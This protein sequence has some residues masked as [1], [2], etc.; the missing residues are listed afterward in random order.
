VI[1]TDP[2]YAERARQIGAELASLGGAQ[3]SVDLLETWSRRPSLYGVKR[4]AATAV[5]AALA[6]SVTQS[7][8]TFRGGSMSSLRGVS[9]V[10]R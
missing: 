7:F 1:L 9:A 5:S 4:L 2:A 6:L 10:I 3:K 8:R